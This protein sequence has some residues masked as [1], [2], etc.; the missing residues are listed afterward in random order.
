MPQHRHAARIARDGHTVPNCAPVGMLSTTA[1]ATIAGRIE[2]RGL[3]IIDLPARAEAPLALILALDQ[4]VPRMP[5][6]RL[7][8]R[9]IEQ[10]D[11]PV[12]AFAPFESS[13][14]VK[15][16]KALLLYGLV[17]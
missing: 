16:E 1:P 12:L 2:V 17:A 15:V 10:I 4:T 8:V 3:G 5:D 13:A 14:P 7:P 11:L 9:T 6:E